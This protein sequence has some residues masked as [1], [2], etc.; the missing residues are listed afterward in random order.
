MTSLSIVHF[1]NSTAI[2]F[3]NSFQP[4]PF[5]NHRTCEPIPKIYLERSV[6]EL[7]IP[8]NISV[9]VTFVFKQQLLRVVRVLVRVTRSKR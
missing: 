6:P 1:R 8:L 2:N 3:E 5:G 9:L 7:R 4:F